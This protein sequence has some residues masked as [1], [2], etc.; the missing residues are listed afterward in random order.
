M[1]KDNLG[2]KG[3]FGLHFQITVHHLRKSGQELKQG[4]NLKIGAEAEAID[5]YYLLVCSSWLAHPVFL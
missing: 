2:G 5:K 3:L 4:R 1:T